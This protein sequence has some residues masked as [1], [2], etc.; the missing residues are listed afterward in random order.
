MKPLRECALL[1]LVAA[2]PALLTCWLHPKR[3]ALSWT[4]PAVPEIELDEAMRWT[5]PALWIDARETHAYGEKHIPG[6]LLLNETEWT[7]LLPGFLEKWQP[8]AK[9]VVYCDSQACDAS[10]AVAR[11][12]QRELNLPD[13]YV[14]KGGWTSW[15]SIHP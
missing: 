11:R 12:L 4:K 5:P 8:D 1:L 6:A 13:V 15:Q 7:H 9:V 2:V 14:L 10:Q 3:V